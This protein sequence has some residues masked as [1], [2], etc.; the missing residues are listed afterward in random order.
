MHNVEFKTYP[1]KV[2]KAKVKKELD[3]YVAM[4]DWQEGCK[5]LAHDIRWLDEKVYSCYEEAEDAI[6][7]L[8]KGWYDQ[9]AVKYY[10]PV[11]FMDEKRQQLEQKRIKA[12]DEYHLRDLKVYPKTLTSAFHECKKC[13]SRLAVPHLQTNFCPV[14]KADLRPEYI[15]KSIAAAEEKLKAANERLSDY[16]D[17]HSKKQIYWLVKIEYHT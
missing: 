4:Q 7:K 8:D 12:M 9:I 17:K 1:E 3:H 6:G 5:G 14:C 15:L 13:G 2:D 10:E 11:A 16:I